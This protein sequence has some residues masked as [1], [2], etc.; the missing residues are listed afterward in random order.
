MLLML[1]PAAAILGLL[2][3]K[4]FTVITGEEILLETA[5]VD[6]RDLFRGNYVQLSYLISGTPTEGY[7]YGQTIYAVL[8]KKETYWTVDRISP[9]KPQTAPG[10]VCMK[11][12]VQ[13]GWRSQIT[14]GI[15]SFFAP[16]DLALDIE[17]QQRAGNVTTAVVAVDTFCN[18]V[19]KGLIVG[20]QVI[21]TR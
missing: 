17:R 15:E 8:S 7:D 2:A 12:T 9:T 1:F 11:G 14:W 13:G 21:A 4:A 6:P 5:P 18:A 19:L 3:F 16:T 20:D 10:E